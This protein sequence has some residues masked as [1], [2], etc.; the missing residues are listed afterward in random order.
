MWSSSVHILISPFK[1]SL[2]IFN[3]PQRQYLHKLIVKKYF[4]R[5]QL[6]GERIWILNYTAWTERNPF[7]PKD[8]HVIL[9]SQ[10]PQ[11]VIRFHLAQNISDCSLDTKAFMPSPRTFWTSTIQSIACTPWAHLDEFHLF[12]NQASVL[13]LS[14]TEAPIHYA[15][16]LYDVL[17][18]HPCD[19][20]CCQ[21]EKNLNFG[22]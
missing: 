10:Q 12:V 9:P 19:G 2:S 18:C 15:L 6:D 1:W 5:G 13:Q 3:S 22:S 16:A 11:S 20:Q 14:A 21:L 7:F 17:R 8:N 4:T